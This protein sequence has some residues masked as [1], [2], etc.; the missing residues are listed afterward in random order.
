MPVPAGAGLAA[1]VGAA[2]SFGKQPP[3]QFP[4]QLDVRYTADVVPA[5]QRSTNLRADSPQALEE[6][7]EAQRHMLHETQPIRTWLSQDMYGGNNK[8]MDGNE[9]SYG[10]DQVGLADEHFFNH[11]FQRFMTDKQFYLGLVYIPLPWQ[12]IKETAVRMLG[13]HCHPITATRRL[14]ATLDKKWVY[15]TLMEQS[16]SGAIGVDGVDWSR[17]LV[18]DSR[19]V[20]TCKNC[21]SLPVPLLYTGDWEVPMGTEPRSKSVFFAGSCTGKMRRFFGPGTSVPPKNGTRWDKGYD[22]AIG[23]CDNKLPRDEFVRKL[24]SST[25]VITPAG[26]FPTTFM[27]FEALQ[28]GALPVMP[29]PLNLPYQD[30][31]VRWPD[32][33]VT[34]TEAELRGGLLKSKVEAVQPKDIA[35]R[36]ALVKKY[37][38]L[39]T[40]DGLIAYILYAVS[41]IR[42]RYEVL[43]ERE[44]LMTLS[45][46]K[47]SKQEDVAPAS[48]LL[49]SVRDY[50]KV[51]SGGELI[52]LPGDWPHKSRHS[53]SKPDHKG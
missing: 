49:Q 2:A 47:R 4:Q 33:G 8:A 35:Q 26:H 37:R 27:I 44:S 22:W 14:M 11:F 30:I 18:F 40:K 16:H 28:A 9:W 15:F 31:G 19:G 41:N 20:H 25:W 12:S 53:K 5:L 7:R 38:G 36:Q 24:H 50:K 3:K 48:R 45:F 51:V 10:A 42:Q 39:F 21:P 52:R 43:A 23:A 1:V 17:V 46:L 29:L 32:L 13:K 6:W 34:V